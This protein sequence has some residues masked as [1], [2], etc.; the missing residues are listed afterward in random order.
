ML[1]CSRQ[2]PAEGERGEAELGFGQVLSG[3]PDL[4]GYAVA[5]KLAKVAK[6]LGPKGIMPNPKTETVGPNVKKMVEELKR[7]KVT[8]KNDATGN[9]HQAIGRVSLESKDLLDN[10]DAVLQAVK[11]NKPA[12]AKGVYIKNVVLTTTMGCWRRHHTL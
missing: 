12:S 4:S 10:L 1:V 9:L 3:G 7:G 11:K 8:L 5:A 6:I 2:V